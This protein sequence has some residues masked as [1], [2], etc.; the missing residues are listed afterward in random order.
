MSTLAVPAAAS[1]IVAAVA[2]LYASGAAIAPRLAIAILMAVVGGAVA[3]LHPD[4]IYCALAFVLGAVPFAAVPG[5]GQPAVLVLAGAVW[6]AV[7]TH[8]IAQ[9]RTSPLELSVALLVWTSAISLT[10]TATGVRDLAEFVKWFGGTSVVFA[11]LRLNRAQLRTFGKVF[12]YGGF[13]GAAVS[14][15]DLFLDKSG[16]LTNHLTVIGIGRLRDTSGIPR[17]PRLTGTYIEPNG[18][19]LVLVAALAVAVALL[20]GA[21]RMIVA[22]V[23]LT[24]LIWTLSRSAMASVLVAVIFMLLFQVMSTSRRIVI[25]TALAV[26][27]AAA[28]SIPVIYNRINNTGSDTDRGAIDRANSLAEYTSS[29]TGSWWFGK[30]WGL[31][32][33]ID[34]IAAFQS[35]HISNTPLLAIYRGGIFVGF[36]F[37]LVL[38]VGC[39][40]AYRN[41]YKRPWESG[42]VGAAF[43]GLCLVAFQLDFPVVTR[44]PLAMVWS[45]LIVFLIA[46]PVVADGEPHD[47]T[48]VGRHRFLD[49][50]PAARHRTPI[51]V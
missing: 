8:P 19:G 11:L 43:V 45:V 42:V 4:W 33:L 38:V 13:V 2:M 18:A 6:C 39:V 9:T 51:D 23:I 32:E 10:V 16:V 21:Q 35:N 5:F 24:A 25:L 15:V 27:C 48:P 17:L 37:V 3:I 30:G 46:N 49:G 29:M 31:P 22:G 20:R 47:S 7:L 1:L 14:L 40:R 26:V 36:A 34:D 12:A 41:L 50:A 44:A 28:L